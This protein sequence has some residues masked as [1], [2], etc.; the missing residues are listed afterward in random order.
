VNDLNVT[1]QAIN[2]SIGM[3]V[4]YSL[5]FIYFMSYFGETIAWICVFLMQISLIAATAVAYLA[6][7]DEMKKY[8]ALAD[9]YS[10]PVL[11]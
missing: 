7:D 4:V 5:F 8:E 6:Y 3:A 11:D 1:S 10:G 2:V 9:T